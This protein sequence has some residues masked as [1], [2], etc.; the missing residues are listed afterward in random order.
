M[1]L[2][3]LVATLGLVSIIGTGT[4]ATAQVA[5]ST[6]TYG[7]SITEIERVAMGWS[8]RKGILGKTIYNDVGAKI[9]KVQD[10]IVDPERNLSY[11]IVGAGGFVGLGQHDVAIPIAQ[12]RDERGKMVMQGGTK[13]ALKALP[14]FHYARTDAQHDKF[15]GDANRD[16]AAA[17]KD[18]VALDRKAAAAAGDVKEKLEQQ[19]AAMRL[20]LHKAE[21]KLA[22]MNRA[23]ISHWR[24]FQGD[25]SEAIARLKKSVGTAS[26]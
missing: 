11:V 20:D 23:G 19:N 8:V 13:E 26:G 4:S 16:I 3:L 12:I 15:V 9:G 10:L 5:G 14:P 21:E 6:T 1:K 22:D 24:E 25:V 2:S 18:I 7:M 17:R